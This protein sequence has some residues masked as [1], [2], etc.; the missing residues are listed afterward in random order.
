MALTFSN[1]LHLTE[2]YHNSSFEHGGS[3]EKAVKLA[4]C[5]S[6]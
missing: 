1:R 3:P 4:L 5:P 2:Y 6:D